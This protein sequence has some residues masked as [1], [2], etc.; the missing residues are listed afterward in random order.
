VLRERLKLSEVISGKLVKW[1][2]SPGS[3]RRRSLS[4]AINGTS[5]A[6]QLTADLASLEDF[7]HLKSVHPNYLGEEVEH[8]ITR[9]TQTYGIRTLFL[10]YVGPQEVQ[11]IG[12][13][14]REHLHC[15]GMS[16][17]H[18]AM[19]DAA[20]EF[21]VERSIA[22]HDAKIYGHEAITVFA[23]LMRRRFPK[24]IGTEYCRTEQERAELFPIRHGDICESEFPDAS[25]HLVVSNDVLEHVRDI[26]AALR[27]TAR[28][29]NA[30]GRLL[31][32]FPFLFDRAV[33]VRF[34][35]L[36]DGK[37]VHHFGPIYHGNPMDKEGGSLVFE[38]PGWDIIDRARQAGFSRAHM[39]FVCDQDKGIV[40][41][42]RHNHSPG[43]VLVAVFDK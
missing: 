17:R 5:E 34:A 12:D 22:D 27:E 37:V 38:I 40:A 18:R 23:L 9:H 11:V 31:A 16:S 41:S 20:L 13:E 29:L 28:I 3:W 42:T 24:F 14:P 8:V 21:L 10:G 26:D 32:T 2:I 7:N 4:T 15:R 39:R 43:G 30:G 36:V 25:F 6:F 1:G 19:L 35:S 33:G